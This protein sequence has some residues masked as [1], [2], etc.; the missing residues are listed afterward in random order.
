MTHMKITWQMFSGATL[1]VLSVLFVSAQDTLPQR[2]LGDLW[3][4][5]F[6]LTVDG[7]AVDGELG[8]LIVKENR[9]KPDTKTI[10]IA[11]FRM[12]STAAKPNAQAEVRIQTKNNTNAELQTKGQL[13]RLLKEYDVLAWIF[14][15]EVVI[16]EN[17]IPHS[18]PILTLSTRYLKDDALLLST[19]VHEQI[20]WFLEKNKKEME[21][22]V[23]DSKVLFPKVPVG[24]SEGAIDEYSTYVHLI[25]C[26]LEYRAARQTLES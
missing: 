3:F 23:K 24:G 6:K 17:V 12:K 5:A 22:A 14:T 18:H 20:H 1:I 4:E 26:H 21:E 11:F 15:R 25:V 13:Q 19:F 9:T 7:K 2:K 16:E 10:E 8:R